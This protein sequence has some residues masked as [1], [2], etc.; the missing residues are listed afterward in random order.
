MPR[1]LLEADGEAGA[2]FV[3]PGTIT[4]RASGDFGGGTLTLQIKDQQS[5]EYRDMTG[6]GTVMAAPADVVIHNDGVNEY[7]V[8][9]AGS[10]SP[11][12][13]WCIEGA[14]LAI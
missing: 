10:S 7:R 12:L 9:L 11:S 2:C 1:G 14:I 4:M 5:G 6:E 3:G 8:S 13:R